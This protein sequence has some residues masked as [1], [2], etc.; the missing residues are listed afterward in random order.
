MFRRNR[1][2]FALKAT[3]FAML[4]L[5]LAAPTQAQASGSSDSATLSAQAA[6]RIVRIQLP[7]GPNAFLDAHETGVNGLD[8]NVVT[9]GNQ[10]NDT[11]R[12]K[13]VNWGG[14]FFSLQQVS[15]GRFMEAKT[16]VNSQVVTRPETGIDLQVWRMGS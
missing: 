4:L 1:K 12:W 5:A 15:S 6:P 16:F 13:I 9:R 11:Q 8:F 7:V 3:A 2:W 10:N 14:G